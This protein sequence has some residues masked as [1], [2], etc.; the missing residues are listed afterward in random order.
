MNRALNADIDLLLS[1]V[2]NDYSA[3]EMLRAGKP[4][5]EAAWS[6]FMFP[7]KRQ[8]NVKIDHDHF[9]IH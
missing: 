4:R 6:V 3:F 7:Q 1:V 5:P 8:G 9:L 2:S